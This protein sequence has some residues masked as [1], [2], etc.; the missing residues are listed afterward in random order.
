MCGVV[1]VALR[2]GLKV[3]VSEEKYAH[4]EGEERLL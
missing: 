4:Q 1:D 3:L 2:G